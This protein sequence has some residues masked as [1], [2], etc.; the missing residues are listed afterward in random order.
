MADKYPFHYKVVFKYIV[1]T[2][3]NEVINQTIE[4]VFR[5]DDPLTNRAKAFADVEEYLS[6][7]K[8]HNRVA[9]NEQGNYI[10]TQPEIVH[11]KIEQLSKSDYYYVLTD[12]Y[13]SYKESISIYLVLDNEEIA[14]R[15]EHLESDENPVLEHLIYRISSQEFDQQE[16]IDNLELIELDLYEVLD[17][18]VGD[19]KKVVYHY[20]ETYAELGE[21]EQ[22]GAKYTILKV[23]FNWI[24]LESYNEFQTKFNEEHQIDAIDYG[25]IIAR[26]ESNQ[27]E[28]KPTIIYNFDTGK[29]SIKVKWIIAKV[30]CSFLN[31]NG[32]TLLI[33]VRDDGTVQGLDYDYSLFE[34]GQKDKVLLELDDLISRY[35]GSGRKPLIDGVIQEVNGKEILVVEVAPS[36]KPV[37]LNNQ[38]DGITRKEFYIRMH[39]STRI[40]ND[41]EEIVEYILTN[42]SQDR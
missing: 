26:G 17:I 30:I 7:L 11:E 41:V 24:T 40:L 20:G 37:F 14:H 36:A 4:N 1:Y 25:S 38:Y 28:F 23:P 21:D 34:S 12:E 33:G 29:G 5:D 15:I 13:E 16:I 19:L 35:F 18:E 32:G 8:E 6:Y 9:V 42:R 3:E 27:I 22:S 31:S 10:I 2:K 39:A